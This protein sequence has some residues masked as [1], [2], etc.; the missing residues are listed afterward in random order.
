MRKHMLP[1]ALAIISLV[2]CTKDKP[3]NNNGGNLP[4][5]PPTAKVLKKLTQIENGATT[6][7]NL[8]YNNKQ[9]VSIKTTDNSDVTTFDYDGDGNVVKVE[10]KD[11]TTHDIYQYVYEG[12]APDRGTFKS[13]SI[14]NGAETLEQDNVIHYTVAGG[15]VTKI[16]MDMNVQQ[17]E[18]NFVLTYNNS[19]N[20]TKI[21]TEG[22]DAYWAEFT[23]GNKK[24]AFPKVFKYVLDQAGYS[25]HFFASNTIL[26]RH[27]HFAGSDDI[28]QNVTYTYDADGNVLTSNDGTTQS[29]FTYE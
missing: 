3:E 17:Q 16:N 26:S 20:V 2:S 21:A 25:L 1:F 29:T 11:Q 22:S 5:P 15:K 23:Y 6:V 13:Y 12:G 24:P 8:S 9:L 19:G 7:Y 4:D 18:L 28:S 27:Y 14:D 10:S